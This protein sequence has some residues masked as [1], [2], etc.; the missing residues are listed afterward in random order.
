MRV[1]ERRDV[2]RVVIFGMDADLTDVARVL[3]AEMRPGLARI[4]RAVH[5]VAMRHVPA[6][7]ALAHADVDDV[8]VGP[9]DSDRAH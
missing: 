8:R 9:R 5:A 1:S 7:A 4:G 6:D 3:E 2:H